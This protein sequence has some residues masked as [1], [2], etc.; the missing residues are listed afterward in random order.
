MG[1]GDRGGPERYGK[2]ESG[3]EEL[4]EFELRD[5]HAA[6]EQRIRYGD[7]AERRLGRTAA[8]RGA[9]HR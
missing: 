4:G 6:D 8:R 9:R 3:G 2:G 5:E 7:V 1:A